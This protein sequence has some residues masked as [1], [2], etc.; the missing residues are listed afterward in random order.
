MNTAFIKEVGLRRWLTRTAIR[1]YYKRIAKRDH[2]MQLPTG[3]WI[4]LPITDHFASEAFITEAD[5]DWGSESLLFSL[6]EKKGAFIDVGAHIGYYSLYMLPGVCEVYCFEP[7]PRVRVLLEN[8]VNGKRHVSVIPW[9]VGAKQGRARFTLERDS[10]VSHLAAEDDDPSKVIVL[11]VVTIDGFVRTRGLTVEAIKIDVEG[12]DAE[13][14]QG[15]LN[16][17]N[18]QQPL[19]LTE[20]RPDAM[21]FGLMRRVGYR[22]FAFVRE[23]KTRAKRMAELFADAPIAGE[24]KMLFLVPDHLAEEFNRRA[25]PVPG[26]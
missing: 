7:D 14:I 10:E 20:A 21:L 6:L 5:V 18:E 3:E 4:T 1:Q 17:L 26:P 12:H 11:D 23:P 8:N 16:V 13:V 25:I 2:A 15:A 22:V 9:A 19:V 24:T